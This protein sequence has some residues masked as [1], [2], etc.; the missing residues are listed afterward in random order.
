MLIDEKCSVEKNFDVLG[1]SR[2]GL[3]M[4]RERVDMYVERVTV[5]G[6]GAP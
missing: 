4:E 3:T 1:A 6:W 5:F 2:V